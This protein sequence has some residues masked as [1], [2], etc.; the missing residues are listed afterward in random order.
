M[1]YFALAEV[2]KVAKTCPALPA[3]FALCLAPFTLS[4]YL[5]VYNLYLFS[6]SLYLF[7]YPCRVQLLYC[8]FPFYVSFSDV[9]GKYIIVHA[10][11]E[12]HGKH[13]CT[14]STTKATYLLQVTGKIKIS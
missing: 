7:P 6:L 5:L 1:I 11:S 14:K 12:K 9:S 4:M 3:L 8:L 10:H 13:G 2:P